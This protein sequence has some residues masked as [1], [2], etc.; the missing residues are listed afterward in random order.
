MVSPRVLFL[1]DGG[2][3]NDNEIR[4]PQWQRWVGEFLVPLLGGTH[5]AWG[6][7]NH[8]VATALFD[9]YRRTM[10]G[11]DD[12]DFNAWLRGYHIAW[13]RGMCERVGVPAPRDEECV[14]LARQAVGYVT[15]RI[16][17]A[18]PGVVETIRRLHRRGYTLFTASGE[19]FSDLDG[20]LTGMG[21]RDCFTGLY[22]P[23]VINTP[24]EGAL[25]YERMFAHAGVRPA[26]AVVVDDNIQALAWAAA[27]RARTV[28]VAPARTAS[29]SETLV[30][31]SLCELPEVLDGA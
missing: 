27:A 1:D 9:D 3:M 13:M 6:E 24:K 26:D 29:E 22:G 19:E 21:V 25:Y 8:I 11:R 18:Y 20:Y 31:R 4:G 17:A 23:D 14:A 28:L 10:S 7:A 5:V 2:V 12:A 30:I 15:P 16:R